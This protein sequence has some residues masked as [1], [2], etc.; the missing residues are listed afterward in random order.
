MA[1][2]EYTLNIYCR[3]L[4]NVYITNH[5]ES[6]EF[7]KFLTQ[8]AVAMAKTMTAMANKTNVK[9]HLP[10]PMQPPE[11]FSHATSPSHPIGYMI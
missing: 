11:C 6:N 2:N 7:L 8:Q 10:Q 5:L 1:H 4:V 9:G 3:L